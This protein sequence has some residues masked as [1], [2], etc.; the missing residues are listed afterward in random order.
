M[1]ALS[2]PSTLDTTTWIWIAVAAL[3]VIGIIAMIARQHRTD[4]LRKRFGPEYDLTV[5]AAGSSGLAE[6]ELVRREKRVQALD[7]HPLTP[8]ARARYSEAWRATQVRFVDDPQGAVAEGNR[9]LNDVMRDRGY[10]ADPNLS[11]EDLSVNHAR[12][13][14]DYRVAHAIVGK[15][16]TTTEELRHA[17]INIRSLFAELIEN[18]P[19]AVADAPNASVPVIRGRTIEPPRMRETEQL[20]A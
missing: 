3:I 7:I 15:A 16:D 20:R 14:S 5:T 8:G 9:L 11:L 2:T 1:L 13:V 18:D 10:P 4:T 17:M 19:M 12:V 6:A